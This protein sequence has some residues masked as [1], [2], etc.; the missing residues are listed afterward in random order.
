MTIT[1]QE[2]KPLVEALRD[3]VDE[4][5]AGTDIPTG[6]THKKLVGRLEDLVN[7]YTEA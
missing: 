5:F 7:D 2:R 1:T 6:F 3:I 4:E